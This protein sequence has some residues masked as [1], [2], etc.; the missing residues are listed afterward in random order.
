L[1]FPTWSV[2]LGQVGFRDSGRLFGLAARLVGGEAFLGLLLHLVLLP[3]P[4][5]AGPGVLG[6]LGLF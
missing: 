1:S 6:R 4:L 5:A 3:A 2:V